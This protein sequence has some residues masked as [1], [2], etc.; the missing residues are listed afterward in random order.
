MIGDKTNPDPGETV[1]IAQD[2]AA[3][4][5]AEQSKRLREIIFIW[6]LASN[7][8]QIKLIDLDNLADEIDKSYAS[9]ENTR[10]QARA[11]NQ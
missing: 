8:G 3:D 7:L 9:F 1:D 10:R 5:R 6:A 2:Q 11:S 4:E